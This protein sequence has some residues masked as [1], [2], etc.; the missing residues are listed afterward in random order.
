MFQEFKPVLNI[1]L[2]FLL[3]YLVLL[4]AYQLY[5]NYFNSQGLD[6][7]SKQVAVWATSLQNFLGYES[8]LY[9]LKEHHCSLFYVSGKYRSR[10][11]EGCNALSITI[12]FW[13]FIFAFYK[14]KKTFIYVCL[15]TLFLMV[16]NVAR[17]AGLNLVY[18]DLPEWGLIGHDYIFP[19]I[20]YGAVVVLWL[21]WIKFF[22]LKH[23]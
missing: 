3:I 17:V 19:A 22:A 6:P 20:I 12:L 1:L 14:G 21:I 4:G 10:M 7:F 16:V 8:A 18:V 9:D 15:G 23:E 5:L 11:V 13:A 2:R